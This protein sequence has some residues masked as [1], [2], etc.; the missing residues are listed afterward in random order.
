MKDCSNCKKKPDP[1]T[2][3]AKTACARCRPWEP[4]DDK[5]T[6]QVAPAFFDTLEGWAGVANL[7]NQMERNA[8]D[9]DA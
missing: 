2:P 8:D 3:Y 4:Q 7:W 5:P 6:V 1:G 9:D